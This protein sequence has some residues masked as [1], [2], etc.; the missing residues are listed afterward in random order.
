[1]YN[2]LLP[3]V[4]IPPTSRKIVPFAAQFCYLKNLWYTDFSNSETAA[5]YGFFRYLPFANTLQ[6]L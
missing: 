6:N 2:I 5:I 1:M 3:A 4:L